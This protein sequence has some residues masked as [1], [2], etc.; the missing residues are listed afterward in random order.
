[1]ETRNPM[2]QHIKLMGDWLCSNYSK[3]TLLTDFE[4]FVEVGDAQDFVHAVVAVL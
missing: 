3:S 4:Q 1:M 2:E